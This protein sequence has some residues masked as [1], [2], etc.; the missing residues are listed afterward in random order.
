MPMVVSLR[1]VF[2]THPSAV[3]ETYF[4]HQAAAFTYARVLFCASAAALV[5]GVL[6]FLFQTTASRAVARMHAFSKARAA[7]AA[8]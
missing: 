8:E 4:Q 6:P 5:H 2:E 1:Q 3:G 7:S